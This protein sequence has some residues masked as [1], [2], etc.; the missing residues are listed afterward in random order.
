MRISTVSIWFLAA[1]GSVA[2]GQTEDGHSGQGYAFF[3]PGAVSHDGGRSAQIGAG[4]EGLVF[5]GLG[6]GA[7]IGYLYPQRD[8]GRGFGL[9]SVNGSYHFGTRRPGSKVVPFVTAGYSLAFRNGHANLANFG[10]GLHYWFTDRVGLR[11]E[12]RDH[13]W[14]CSGCTTHFWGF[15]FGVAFR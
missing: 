3:A 10:G 4:A 13:V 12:F 5:R 8:F 2:W 15:R 11:A 9:L 1:C 7:D 14:G 6:A